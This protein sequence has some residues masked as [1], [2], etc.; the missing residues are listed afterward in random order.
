MLFAGCAAAE[1]RRQTA[2]LFCTILTAK[3]DA[4]SKRITEFG[5]KPMLHRYSTSFLS[6]SCPYGK[7]ADMQ[8]SDHASI[9]DRGNFYTSNSNRRRKSAVVPDSGNSLQFI[10]DQRIMHPVHPYRKTQISDRHTHCSAFRGSRQ[11]PI[12]AKHRRYDA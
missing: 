8:V 4:H 1:V 11:C 10:H 5:C 6:H 12:S 9:C 3:D 2:E 7:S